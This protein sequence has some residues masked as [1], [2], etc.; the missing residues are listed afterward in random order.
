[1]QN[2]ILITL[3]IAVCCGVYFTS[4]S[5]NNKKV[6][7]RKPDD[8]YTEQWRKV[9]DYENRGLPKSAYEM[10]DTIYKKA[11]KENNP[12]Q[13]IK[14]VIHKLKFM[15]A[16]EEDALAKSLEELRKEAE[17]AKSP[18]KPV[19]HSMLAE[20]YW[21]YYQQ[22]Q[23]YI[24]QRSVT[25]DFKQEDIRTWDA[26]KLVE[27]CV[28]QYQASLL[29][30]EN[31][32][33]TAIDIY[34]EILNY[35]NSDIPNGRKLRPTLYDFLAHRAIDFFMSS[36]PQ[37]TRPG[38]DFVIGPK[39]LNS[40]PK[41]EPA[42]YFSP[43][44]SFVQFQIN[45]NSE[46]AAKPDTVINQSFKYN[47]ITTLQ[48]LLKFHSKDEKPEALVYADLKRLAFLYQN[49]TGENKDDLYL[50][51]LQKLEQ[52]Y[53][54]EAISTEVS[55]QIALFYHG[56][57]RK[58]NPLKP[59][60]E[61]KI[62]EFIYERIRKG[63]H[64]LD[65]NWKEN[66]KKEKYKW[67]A[68]YAYRIC[69]DAIKRFP[70]SDGAQNCRSLQASI[71][72]KNLNL[73]LE[74]VNL[75]N[76][77]FRTLITYQN[78]DKIYFRVIKTN[79]A[80]RE[81]V[82]NIYRREENKDYDI[83][84]EQVLIDFYAKKKATEEFTL[85]L[86]TDGD[87]Q[88]HKV[89]AKIPALAVGEY[90]ILSST[91]SQFTY[92]KQAVAFAFTTI[93]NISYV[94]R[95]K[96]NTLEFTILNRKTGETLAGVKAQV[97]EQKYN[98]NSN[99][100]EYSY[101]AAEAYVSDKEGQFKILQPKKSRSF[102]LELSYKGDKLR[103][104]GQENDNYYSSNDYL[105]M[106][107][108][109]GQEYNYNN[110]EKTY[111]Q[112][113]LFTDRGIYRPGQ[114]I[115]FKGITLEKYKGKA[116]IKVNHPQT[117]TLYDVNNQKVADV[118]LTTNE[119]GSFS[120]SFT[121]PSG[122]L[123]GQMRIQTTSNGSTYISVED[124][125]RPKFEVSIEKPKG[126]Y[127]LNDSVNVKGKALAYSGANIDGASVSYRVVRTAHFPY[128]W[129][130]RYSY[131]PSSA[132]V[133]ITNG[134]TTTDEKGEFKIN[135]NALPDLSVPATS[136]P[137]FTYQIIA[138]VTDLNGETHSISEY[139]Q[140]GYASL[141]LAVSIPDMVN[142]REKPQLSVQTLNLN[143]QHEPVK[144]TVKIYKLKNPE[145][146][147]RTRLW[148]QPDKF[149]FSKEEFYKTFPY[150]L[151]N[152]ENNFFKWEKDKETFNA[153]LD[154]AKEK[155]LNIKDLTKWPQGKYLAEVTAKDK[156]GQEVK[157]VKYFT[158]FDG[159]M[160]TD[161]IAVTETPNV[162]LPAIDW[163]TPIKANA[164]PG[165]TAKILAGSSEKIKVLYEIEH[166]GKI[167]Q[168]EWLD[169]GGRQR[170]L[171]IPIK[172]EYRGNIGVHYTFI[173]ENRLYTHET[174]INVP[175]SN[176]QL[177]ITFET[178][179]NKLLPGQKEE[180][181]LII[182]G[183]NGEKVA[184]EM[185]A[186]LYDASLDA[187]R[188]NNWYF[189]VY[190]S[191]YNQLSWRADNAF[192]FSNSTEYNK[193]WNE[194][195]DGIYYNYDY[196]NWFGYSFYQLS[197]DSRRGFKYDML[198]GKAAGI[199]V[200][201]LREEERKQDAPAP[202]VTSA[203]PAGS[204]ILPEENFGD[205]KLKDGM[206]YKKLAGKEVSGGLRL[207]NET[208]IEPSP[209]G[210]LGGVQA[211]KDFNETAFFYPHLQTNEKGEIIIAFTIPEALTKW[212]MLGLAHTK[213][214][215]Y[216]L[217]QNELV[218]QKE[219]MVVPNAPRFFREGDDISFT[220]KITNLS[221]KDLNGET[222]LE[223]FDALTMKPLQ[224]IVDNNYIQSGGSIAIAS[225]GERLPREIVILK[226]PVKQSFQTKKGQSSLVS[227]NI[228][229]PEGVQAIT[230]KVVAKAGNFSDGEEMAVPVLTNRM[231]VTETL[232]LSVRGNQ[233]KTFML[234]KL[235]N[236]KST[237]LRN[238]KLTLEYSSNP[239]WYAVQALPYLMEYPYECAEQTFNRLYANS[240]ATH[241]A[242][243]NPKLKRVFDTWK[244]GG[245]EALL[246]NL[247]KN[248][249][250]K[251]LLLEETPWI[252]DAQSESE[253]KKRIALLFDLNKMSD[254]LQRALNKLNK[255]QASNG[256]W[257]WFEGMPE[258]RYI[259]QYI[260][261]G[262][263][264]LDRLGV[265]N[266]RTD[267][268]AWNMS[269]K[270]IAW[271]DN[272]IKNDYE[273]ILRN[274]KRGY[275]K[276]SDNHLGQQIL[277]YF[278]ARSYF[279][280]VEVN[281]TNKKAF[282]Y[283]KGQLGSYW[284]SYLKD[285]NKYTL[286]M[287]A[288]SMQRYGYVKEPQDIVKSLKE[289]ALISEEMGMYWKENTWGYYWYQAPVETQALMVE[290]FDEIAKDEKAV[291]DLK[292]WLLKQKQTQDWKTTKATAEACY[293]L[294]IR[295]ADW[296]TSDNLVEITIGSQ[297]VNPAKM[298][299]LKAEAGT[300]YFK[301]S[302]SGNEIKPEMGKVTVTP[303]AA[304]KGG[305]S[306]GAMYWQYFEQLDKITPGKTSLQLKKQLFLQKNT[307]TGPVISP[308][309]EKTNLK[310]GDK[311][312][313]RIELRVDRNMEYVHLK[314]MRA[315]CFEPLNVISQ[316]KWQDGLGYYESTRDAATNFFFAYLPK[317]TYVFEYPL[318]VTHTG[319]FSNGITTI[320]CM[321]APE[322][323]SHS[324][325]I[326]VQV[327][328]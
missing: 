325:G 12:A 54:K 52:H 320:Q 94:N 201:G 318:A 290:V 235:L 41:A 98:Y 261:A 108:G 128:W 306:W 317:G 231:L 104:S 327:K 157:E 209:S 6:M 45:V 89:E 305:I 4:F 146:A 56:Q 252:R 212:K 323:S 87:Y 226:S 115:Y 188:P 254:E 134:L 127:R 227:W 90:I 300:G 26:K 83:D 326:R 39:T 66:Y 222:Q 120:G 42:G 196:L 48:Q 123:N 139:V 44:N 197:R 130:Y 207:Q 107:F 272:Q 29:D 250:L 242:N 10:A 203:E 86:P 255:M 147:F 268:K 190:N 245:S 101:P 114:T 81:Q 274:E 214:L 95:T 159:L 2:K 70:E 283:F 59:E 113:T 165:E 180:W 43:V 228:K 229:I 310:P 72:T 243:A 77:P 278:Y 35:E 155:P 148:E 117:V 49:Y 239:A 216:G 251:S 179:R 133:E 112:T 14:A 21:Q 199:V 178:F 299:N 307:A 131:Y 154:T 219:L 60:Y 191:Y 162:P 141:Q 100:S 93:S 109:Q 230:Y 116:E 91:G 302:W 295:G 192:N 28:F 132:Q 262:M 293:A 106:A 105:N 30:A 40:D 8:T 260:I 215:K 182:K 322:F 186:T 69:E 137:T 244:N 1:M 202:P 233:P 234:D 11:V 61:N 296:L 153:V 17:E 151:Y 164:E 111:I 240:L 64:P 263:G 158:V 187:F 7:P 82:S 210:D 269:R 126:A 80:E 129:Y 241:V 102:Y 32:Q 142:T 47:A 267:Q 280:D 15:S 266:I 189:N 138:D 50:T 79:Q 301:T 287:L 256:A 286:G 121:A 292:V 316:Y 167:V 221:E 149:L 304:K 156:Y 321:Y 297:N 281:A 213:D 3:L 110:T 288:L 289:N 68:E 314:D 58:Y 119:Y 259:T 195:V 75:P 270:A 37:I 145:K 96:N 65:S 265:K 273:E 22:N 150:D 249:E 71:E 92:K 135:F 18:A 277:Y 62:P 34:N 88:S 224:G 285:G 181:K 311:V 271:M 13:L 246:S 194:R 328:K 124:Y 57:S 78:I 185:L 225:N 163:F 217:T 73:T 183:K 170:L 276:I 206:V 99:N 33:N 103:I 173:K 315:S 67:D 298:E 248:Q 279:K 172:E 176:K 237:T 118:E 9:K 220:A 204:T 24:L 27:Q 5:Q 236:N 257:P 294:L 23:W 205:N 144:A 303:P 208:T 309:D 308:I 174:V 319:N 31:S 284:T 63:V 218:T 140:V 264:H 136:Q 76:E 122:G 84:Y 161:G 184:A 247:E 51:A 171:S 19:L 55:H 143:G 258:D 232:P 166:Q 253:R 160:A 275:G 168:K 53:S 282:D 193:D 36:E 152:D 238:H 85:Q 291:D 200:D 20:M 198:Q 38:N 125:K 313:V 177:D 312:K 211:R 25:A 46:K 324:E 175:Y 97:Y 16:V 74:D 223:L 169:I